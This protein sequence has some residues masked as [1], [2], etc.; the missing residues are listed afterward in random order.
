MELQDWCT[1]KRSWPKKRS[2]KTFKQ[3]F[4]V[5]IST[6][7]YDLEKTPVSKEE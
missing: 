3:W 6:A 2:Y 7:V 1:D 5:D 4:R